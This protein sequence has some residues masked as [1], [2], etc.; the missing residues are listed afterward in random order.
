[1]ARTKL[2]AR[3]G[4]HSICKAIT[5]CGD[6]CANRG[7][8]GDF[9]GVHMPKEECP[10]CYENKRF[11]TLKCG[12]T[13]CKDCSTRWFSTKDTCPMCREV[14]K[15]REPKFGNL[16]TARRNNP[17]HM[18]ISDLEELQSFATAFETARVAYDSAQEEDNGRLTPRSLVDYFDL[19]A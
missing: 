3:M 11:T 18:L 7:K 10:V 15:K 12:H 5:K 14:V 2:Q 6:R 13:I 9:C 8:Y 4:Q 16:A 19:V 17:L 1:M